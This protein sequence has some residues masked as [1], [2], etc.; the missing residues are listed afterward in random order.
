MEDIQ[1]TKNFK[2]SEFTKSDTAT[3]K[4]ID[5]TPNADELNNIT[6]LCKEVLQ[7]IREAWGGSISVTSGFRSEKLNKAVGGAKN[8]SHLYGAAADIKAK[9][10]KQ[11][12]DLWNMIRRM[13]DKGDIKVHQLI[14]EKGTKKN[15]QWLHISIWVDGTPRKYTENQILYIY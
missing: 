3:K 12:I 14:W 1:I 6:R 10:P 4:K 9:D 2:L 13:I 8:S 7:P 15:P 11:N 5:N